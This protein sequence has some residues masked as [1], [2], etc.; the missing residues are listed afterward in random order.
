MHHTLKEQGLRPYHVQKVQALESA[1]FPRRV[2]Y[3]EWLLHQCCEPP[4]F[5]NCIL[6]TDEAE[7]TRNAI[8]NSHNIHIIWSDENPHARQ[9]VRFQRS[10]GRKS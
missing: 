1:D 7:F 5:L 10:V 4:T 3:C 8:F 6:F 9:E 2:K